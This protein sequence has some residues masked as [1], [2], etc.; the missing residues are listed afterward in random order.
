MSCRRGLTFA[1]S[2]KSREG[3]VFLGGFS[4]CVGSPALSQPL[5]AKSRGDGGLVG[6]LE[7]SH[8]AVGGGGRSSFRKG[9][10]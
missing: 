5:Q 6:C 10:N 9:K 8:R 7:R 3:V 1:L 2:E 4:L